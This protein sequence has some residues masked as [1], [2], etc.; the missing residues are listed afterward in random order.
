M[1]GRI[2]SDLHDG[3]NY[4]DFYKL[5]APL[6]VSISD[7]RIQRLNF[8]VGAILNESST[9]FPYA[10]SCN[11]KEHSINLNDYAGLDLPIPAGQS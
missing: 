7:E 10:A 4:R 3:M 6:I 5:V 8:Q 1:S 11:Y 2:E 9:L